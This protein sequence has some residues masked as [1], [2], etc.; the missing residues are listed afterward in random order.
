MKIL[1]AVDGSEVSLRATRKLIETVEWFKQAPEV[2]LVTINPPLPYAG[3]A[4]YVL[5]HSAVEQFYKDQADGALKPSRE[6]LDAAN[7]RYEI[8][9]TVGDVGDEINRIADQVQ[10]DLIFMGTR[11]LS[12]VA[13][14]VLGSVARKVVHGARVPVLLV[15]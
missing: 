3:R 2:H 6:A 8:H 7:I 9:T 13:D 11:G 14:F 15:P 1:L 5:G 10:C 4:S 12:A